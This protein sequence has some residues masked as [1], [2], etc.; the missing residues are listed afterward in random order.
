[1][2]RGR[3]L[4]T[5]AGVLILALLATALAVL[6]PVY[7]RSVRFGRAI[8]AIARRADAAGQADEAV[9]AAVIES[10]ARLSLPI[11]AA[12]LKLDRSSGRLRIDLRYRVPVNALFYTVDLHFHPR[13]G[14]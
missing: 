2:K 7:Y 10:A 1:M 4:R 13:A 11:D 8:Q 3:A 5:A 12:G 9:R 14:E 6:V